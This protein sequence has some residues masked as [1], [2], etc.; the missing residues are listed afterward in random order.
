M[1]SDM[2][3]QYFTSKGT[4]YNRVYQILNV[5]EDVFSY[6]DYYYNKI[7]F[8]QNTE[9]SLVVDLVYQESFEDDSDIKRFILPNTL[10]TEEYSEGD[11]ISFW[12]DYIEKEEASE[13]RYSLEQTLLGLNEE[14]L[15]KLS[16]LEVDISL[17]KE[18]SY[19]NEI[20]S[21][22]MEDLL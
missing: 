3:E 19:R 16:S 18:Y 20:L 5:L 21:K 8:V 14:L 10:F 17:L 6:G 12:K 7:T 22:L 15:E 4:L 9:E 2:I 13:V 1:K 11:V